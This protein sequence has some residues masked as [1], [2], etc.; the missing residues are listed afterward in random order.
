VNALLQ[1]IEA[2]ARGKENLM[3]IFV[4]AAKA[5]VTLGEICTVLRQCW[6]VHNP[7][8]SY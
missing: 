7:M 2:A 4:E 3:P 8:Q 1:Q 6:G 5:R